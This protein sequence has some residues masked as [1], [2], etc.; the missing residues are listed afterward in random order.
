MP[1]PHPL[2][3]V[4]F[5]VFEPFDSPLNQLDLPALRLAFGRLFDR[6]ANE[7]FRLGRDLDE[8]IFERFLRCRII[9]GGEF[10]A[11]AQPLS[12]LDRLV[13]TIRGAMPHHL[14]EKTHALTISSL[15]V[16]VLIAADYLTRDA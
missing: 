16:R 12:N 5:S 13:A 9:D 4:L 8:V 10:S 15:E 11:P 6:A 2:S 7:V 3:A 14:S 1:V